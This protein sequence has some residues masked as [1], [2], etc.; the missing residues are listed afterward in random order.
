MEGDRVPGGGG[1]GETG[2]TEGRLTEG[3]GPKEG[4]PGLFGKY[5]DVKVLCDVPK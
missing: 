4:V 1:T 5:G 3:G 2:P